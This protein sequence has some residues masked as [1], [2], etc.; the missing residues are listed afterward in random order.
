MSIIWYPHHL[1]DYSKNTRQLSLLEHGAYR[2]IL[3]YYYTYGGPI[4]DDL[5][6]INR[7]CSAHTPTERRAVSKVIQIYFTR[8]DGILIHNHASAEILKQK[9]ISELRK[10]AAASAHASGKQTPV[11]NEGNLQPTTYNQLSTNVDSIIAKEKKN[12]HSRTNFTGSQAAERLAEKYR[13]Q[14]LDTGRE[15]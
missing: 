13:S 4:P 15:N 14:S 8:G 7:A 6:S 2:L 1:G 3:D 12:G 5:K 11:L 9:K 10:K